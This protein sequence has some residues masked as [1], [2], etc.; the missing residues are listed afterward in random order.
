M[1]SLL[2]LV[3]EKELSMYYS[4]YEEFGRYIA[5]AGVHT[6]FS[7]MKPLI[8]ISYFCAITVY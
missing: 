7:L 1:K 4:L 5:K 8:C 6:N 3:R 2:S